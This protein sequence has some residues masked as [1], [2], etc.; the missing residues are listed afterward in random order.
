MMTDMSETGN[1]DAGLIA[2][3]LARP[4]HVA[5]RQGDRAQ[6]YGEL[7]DRARRGG[8]APATPRVRRGG[9]VAVMIPNSFEFFEAGARAR[10]PGAPRLARDNHLQAGRAGVGRSRP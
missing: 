5:L 3:A 9:R 8:H 7:D 2:H 10:P 6:T 1:H 4:D